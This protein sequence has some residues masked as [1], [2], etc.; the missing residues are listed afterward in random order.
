MSG[1]DAYKQYF[2]EYPHEYHFIINEEEKCEQLRPFLVLMVPVAPHNLVDRE[3]IRRTWGKESLILGNVVS[4]FF[5]LGL[6]GEGQGDGQLQQQLR[7]ESREHGDLLQSDFLD[8]YQNLTIKTMVMM[9]WL[10]THC[11]TAT[12]AMKIDS[13]MFLNVRNLVSMLLDT[14]R[15]GY[16]TGLVETDAEV[17]RDPSSKW[18]MPVEVLPEP[19]YPRYA[20]GL[21]YVVSLDLPR[22]LVEASRHIR[23]LY[24]EDVHLGFCMK[25]L[26]IDPSD[27]PKENYF[28]VAPVPYDRCDY[29]KLI[30]TTT[31]P[32][33]D[34][35]HVWEDFSGAELVCQEDSSL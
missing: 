29:S 12:Y 17:Q 21:G 19:V 24:I 7:Q 4:L 6:A 14:P 16:M 23:P 5:L 26:G 33:S 31:E 20:L 35:I 1:E 10:D 22:K 8:C 13:D 9:E 3:T 27:P 32:Y 2:V 25:Y 15:R 30:A 34:R 11:S 28:H 18:Y